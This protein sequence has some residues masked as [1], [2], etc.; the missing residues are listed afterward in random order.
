MWLD[1]AVQRAGQDATFLSYDV[2]MMEDGVASSLA[3]YCNDLQRQPVRLH[4]YV[5]GTD[6]R[7]TAARTD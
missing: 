4:D 1:W 2:P 7:L 3:A 6:H 5:P